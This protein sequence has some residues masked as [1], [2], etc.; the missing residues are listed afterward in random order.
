MR[1]ESI[2]DLGI[3]FLLL[4][5]TACGGGSGG[6][7]GGSP[8]VTVPTPPPATTPPPPPTTTPPPGTSSAR[9]FPATAPWVSFYGTAAQMGNLD[10]IAAKFRIINIDA[11][12]DG[13]NFTAAQIL[14]L[15]NNGQNRVISYLNL[16]S[17]E[18]FRSYW[19][20]AP[21]GILSCNANR[22]AQRGAYDGYPDEV[23][24]DVGNAD[25]QKLI[26]DHVAPRLVA[27]GIDGFYFDNMEII[28]HGTNTTNGPCDASCSQG[29]LDLIR[30]LRE[31][32]P[33]LLFVLQNTASDVSRLGMTGGVTLP[34]LLDGIA[35][36]EVYKP[37]ADTQVQN[38]L[39]RWR[40][41]NLMPGGRPFF[42]GT[43]D[44]VGS[45]SNTS[46]ARQAYDASRAAGFSPYAADASAGQQVVC[47]WSF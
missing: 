46:E 5:T 18:Q 38:Y 27:M 29:G 20:T 6:D 19:A 9:G 1:N 7:D 23:W 10:S 11:D 31:K 32:Y 36:E 34:S 37:T 41:M 42:I 30:K 40:A 39:A 17:C 13:G 22:A 12:P 33:D 3:V 26:L 35:H 2:W 45:C 47:N 43:L 14:Q 28:E 16:G 44:Y 8:M 25:Y 15:R 4:S 24:M 21:A